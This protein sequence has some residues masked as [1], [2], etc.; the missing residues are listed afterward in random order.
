MKSLL[1]Y[2]LSASYNSVLAIFAIT[3]GVLL[4]CQTPPVRASEDVLFD[5]LK[6]TLSAREPPR[7]DIVIVAITEETLREFPYRAPVNRTFLAQLLEDID[8]HA[9]ERIGLDIVIDRPSDPTSDDRLANTIAGLES[10][11]TVAASTGANDVSG[12]EAS[13]L[14]SVRR[15]SPYLTT[16]GHDNVVRRVDVS[17]TP[18]LLAFALAGSAAGPVRPGHMRFRVFRGQ[19]ETYPFRI[20][21]AHLVSELPASSNWLKNRIVLIGG[22]LEDQDRHQISLRFAARER[23]TPGVIVHAYQL[24]HLLDGAPRTEAHKMLSVLL[25]GGFALLGAWFGARANRFGSSL[26]ALVTM[27]FCPLL[28]SAAVYHSVGWPMAVLAPILA[29]LT[30]AGGFAFYRRLKVQASLAYVTEAFGRYMD[31]K[32][33]KQLSALP[34][35]SYAQPRKGSATFLFTDMNGFTDFV[36]QHTPE[37]VKLAL[38]RYIDV[39]ART[40]SAHGGIVDRFVGDGVH[41]F[42]GMPIPLAHA[43]QAALDCT[44]EILEA[45]RS[46]EYQL[47]KEGVSIGSTRIGLHTGSALFGD[48]GGKARADFTAHGSAVNIAARLLDLAGQEGAEICATMEVFHELDKMVGWSR[49]ATDHLAGIDKPLEIWSWSGTNSKD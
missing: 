18:D 36:D 41:A 8:R 16:D 2:I 3:F 30:S 37:E 33:V 44:F 6:S 27:A 21:P 24:A 38:D 23:R 26:V 48:F 35:F 11:L 42:F 14:G 31:P 10:D 19:G 25:T 43:S 1:Q 17:L 40:I 12:F 45:T 15:G 7:A 32:L 9:P 28:L 39:I 34:D 22:I 46:L 49:L 4:V 13:L 20:V 5:M 47:E 29:C